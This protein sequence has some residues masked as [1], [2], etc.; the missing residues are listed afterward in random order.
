MAASSDAAAAAADG[1]AGEL[2]A[3]SDWRRRAFDLYRQVREASD[4]TDAWRSWRAR[5][6]D[7]FAR[8]PQSPLQD[9]ER[10]SF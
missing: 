10:A 6:D 9:H 7:L 4:P 1:R 2:L 5:R 3:L 8:H